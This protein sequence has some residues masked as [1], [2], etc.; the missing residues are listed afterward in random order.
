MG[1]KTE[2][3][4]KAERLKQ[5]E[6]DAKILEME[7][8]LA[9]FNGQLIVGVKLTARVE[10]GRPILGATSI[11]G[12]G[13]GAVRGNALLAV[14]A[15]AILETFG[16]MFEVSGMPVNQVKS[17]KEKVEGQNAETPIVEPDKTGL[18]ISKEDG[19]ADDDDDDGGGVDGAGDGAGA[20]VGETPAGAAGERSAGDSAADAGSQAV[21]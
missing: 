11:I 17:Q 6:V 21:G 4:K 10:N 8:T 5:E 19:D 7:K 16:N 9:R 18:T 12:P 3:A 20:G 15:K 2:N 14:Q 1:N 13:W